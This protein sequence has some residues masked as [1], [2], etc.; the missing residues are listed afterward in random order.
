MIFSFGIVSVLIL[1]LF[2]KDIYFGEN[3]IVI[4]GVVRQVKLLKFFRVLGIKLFY[5]VV[6]INLLDEIVVFGVNSVIFLIDGFFGILVDVLGLQYF[7]FFFYLNRL[8]F[9]K[10]VIVIV[11]I[12]DRIL[13]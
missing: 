7:V 13:L 9:C 10:F 11:G 12:K 4:K 1:V 3:I 2:V 5:K 8:R 6:Y